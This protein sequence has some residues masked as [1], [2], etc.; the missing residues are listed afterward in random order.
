VEAEASFLAAIHNAHWFQRDDVVLHHCRRALSFSPHIAELML[1]YIELQTR[2]HTP[3]LMGE[4]DERIHALSSPLIHHYLFRSNGKLLDRVLLGAMVEALAEVQIEAGALLDRFRREEHSVTR[5]PVNLIDYYYC[6]SAKQ[7]REVAW[8]IE[9]KLEKQYPQYYKAY[10]TE[11]R[12]IFVGEAGCLL[13]LSLA[14]RLPQSARGEDTISLMVNGCFQGEMEIG[15]NWTTWDIAVNGAVLCDGLNEVVVRWPM[16]VFE[17][18]AA[19][20]RSVLNICENKF[21]DLFPIFGEIHSF[22]ACD[23]RAVKERTVV[24]EPELAALEV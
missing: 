14:C 21:P 12:F 23:A 19:L 9:Q 15:R 6:A 18:S 1:A 2:N 13:Q 5:A 20:E 8:V 10:E 16:P 24:A 7:P 22:T 17:G 11:S 4:A 3:M